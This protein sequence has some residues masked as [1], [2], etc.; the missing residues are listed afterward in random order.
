GQA[1]E[2]RR[3]RRGLAIGDD[4]IAVGGR[5]D[6]RFAFERR[7]ALVQLH[8]AQRAQSGERALAVIELACLGRVSQQYAQRTRMV[9]VTIYDLRGLFL[10]GGELAVALKR[11]REV[12]PHRVARGFGVAGRDRVVDAAVLFLD[13]GEVGAL[14]AHALGQAAHRSPRD[15]VPADELQK[16][17]ELR[18]AGGLRDRAMKAEILVD[19]GA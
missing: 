6:E 15:E 5:G 11:A 3:G 13:E 4:E 12:P 16:A 8:L 14:P 19:R 7:R 18:V 1:L 10:L 17:R 9:T 2:K